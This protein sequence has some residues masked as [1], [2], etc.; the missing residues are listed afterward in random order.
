[1]TDIIQLKW[2]ASSFTDIS[3][4]DFSL[5]VLSPEVL[6]EG[7]NHTFIFDVAVDFEYGSISDLSPNFEI[8][9]TSMLDG[10]DAKQ[11]Y[12]GTNSYFD[13]GDYVNR[14]G[15]RMRNLTYPASF[16][17]GPSCEIGKSFCVEVYFKNS[18][19]IYSADM[20]DLICHDIPCQSKLLNRCR[21]SNPERLYA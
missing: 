10:L 9:I 6:L 5:H 13:N 18:W 11:D 2:Y 20:K 15:V 1:M 4:K 17:D 7:N 16:L 8:S 12:Y 21:G 19:K 3:F 14:T